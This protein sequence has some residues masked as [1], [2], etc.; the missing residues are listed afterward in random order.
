MID[1]RHGFA[2]DVLIEE[3][4][5]DV[6]AER[7]RAVARSAAGEHVDVVE[8]AEAVDEADEGDD[9]DGRHH[10]GQDDECVEPQS[11][12]AVDD[13]GLLELRPESSAAR[14][15]RIR[16]ANDVHCRISMPITV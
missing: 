13:R 4:L 10:V 1:T 6:D 15:R 14:S 5:V 11:D 2:E 16:K 9:D 3:Q 8:D 7:S 12:G